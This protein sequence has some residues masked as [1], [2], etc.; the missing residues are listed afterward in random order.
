MERA[1]RVSHPFETAEEADVEE[2]LALSGSERLIASRRI[3]RQQG[4]DWLC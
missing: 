2:W 3:A 1:V 4:L